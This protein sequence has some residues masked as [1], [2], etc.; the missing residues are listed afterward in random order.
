MNAAQLDAAR[1]IADVKGMIA[2]QRKVK[3]DLEAKGLPVDRIEDLI[4]I[5]QSC[6]VIIEASQKSNEEVPIA[7][8]APSVVAARAA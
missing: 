7:L 6:L 2:Q 3:S 1:R 5:P 8:S 4:K